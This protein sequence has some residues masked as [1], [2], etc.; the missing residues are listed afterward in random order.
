MKQIHLECEYAMLMKKA[1]QATSR[2]EAIACIQQAT[3]L[4][5]A[6]QVLK[7]DP[8]PDRYERW[9][10]GKNGFDDYAERLH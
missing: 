4:Q 9:C 1:E 10:G 2:Q 5:A 6:M 7:N 8:P 3:K